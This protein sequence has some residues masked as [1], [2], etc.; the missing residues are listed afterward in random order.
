MPDTPTPRHP[1]A[2]HP[3]TPTLDTPTPDTPTLDTPTGNQ[4]TEAKIACGAFNRTTNLG[5]PISVRIKC[6][7]QRK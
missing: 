6:N 7:V 1:D 3:D 4:R 5:I 2:Q